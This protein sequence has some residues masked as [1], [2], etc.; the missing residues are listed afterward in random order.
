[1]ADRRTIKFSV[2][3]VD[4]GVHEVTIEQEI[5]N[6]VNLSAHCSC[7][8]ANA[9]TFCVHR[10]NILEGDISGLISDNLD[11]VE[12]LRR[13]VRGS[14]IEAAMQELARAKGDLRLAFEKV[15][16]C[17]RKLAQRMLD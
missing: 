4:G 13:W 10:F 15:D 5:N 11:D 3:D 16:L 9:E 14:D 6:S 1:M 8:Q 7:G 17:R 2:Q 12:T